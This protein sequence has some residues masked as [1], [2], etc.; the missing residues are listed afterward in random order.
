[1]GEGM[2]CLAYRPR[3]R[4]NPLVT[5]PVASSLALML[6]VAA[7]PQAMAACV[8]S[9][10]PGT[11]VD[12]SGPDSALP[13]I[14]PPLIGSVS[15]INGAASPQVGVRLTTDGTEFTNS[16]SITSQVT[17]LVGPPNRNTFGVFGI[18]TT[19]IGD[20]EWTIVNNGNVSAVHN[21]VGQLAAIGIIG[22]AGEASVENSGTLSITR[23]TITL[24]TN[25]AAS[26]RWPASTLQQT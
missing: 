19:D 25:T 10:T 20:S 15:N 16:T 21:G 6:S 1:M 17:D 26:L 12:C 8:I 23:G 2:S 13:Q 14:G 24:S 3:R 11:I 22:D 18:A 7:S 5:L 9:A 4:V